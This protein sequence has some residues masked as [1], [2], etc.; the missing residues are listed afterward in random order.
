MITKQFIF[1]IK[2]TT[3]LICLFGCGDDGVVG[4]SENN[5]SSTSNLS[6]DV[7][8]IL[9]TPT[10]KSDFSVLLYDDNLSTISEDNDQL[11][12]FYSEEPLHIEKDLL[13]EL[14]NSKVDQNATVISPIVEIEDL[15]VRS[16]DSF[17]Q[18]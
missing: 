6:V 4:H 11:A 13:V 9:T 18:L 10:G 3:F 14:P 2:L 17:N 7:V 5:I 8:K 1:I 15:P 12:E 16:I